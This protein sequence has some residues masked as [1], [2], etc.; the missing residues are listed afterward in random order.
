M[1]KSKIIIV[2]IFVGMFSS[3]DDFLN[4]FPDRDIFAT[5]AN[6]YQTESDFESAIMGCYKTFAQ[7]YNDNLLIIANTMADD[8]YNARVNQFDNIAYAKLFN[9]GQSDILIFWTLWQKSYTALRNVNLFLYY[10]QTANISTD[11]KAKYEA[12]ARFLRAYLYFDLVKVWGDV[13]LVLKPLEN[14]NEAYSILRTPKPEVYAQIY[15]DIDFAIRNLPDIHD[16]SRTN[17]Y[18]A[19]LLK[20]RV[21]LYDAGSTYKYDNE[22]LT[23][24]NGVTGF[25]LMENFSDL[26]NNPTKENSKES[27]FELQFTAATGMGTKVPSSFTNSDYVKGVPVGSVPNGMNDCAPSPKLIEIMNSDDDKRKASTWEYYGKSIGKPLNLT[28]PV[29]MKF[30]SMIPSTSFVSEAGNNIILMR[31]ADVLLLRAEINARLNP[32]DQ[33]LALTDL[34]LVRNRAGAGSLANTLTNDEVKNFIDQERFKELAFEGQRW[35]DLIRTGRAITVI[36]EFNKRPD[37]LSKFSPYVPNLMTEDYFIFAIPFQVIVN[38]P[39][40]TQNPNLN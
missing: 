29:N 22:A 2:A 20:A 17:V 12:E 26:F 14:I 15:T 25:E 19:R 7:T 38:N 37:I 32:N 33:T 36:N 16:P 31:F 18:A 40:I 9:P 3:C 6:A 28:N 23:L 13:P 24:L 8:S 11:L 39:K 27:I 35:W 5:K 4:V 34:N 30:T 21:L 10:V 1:K